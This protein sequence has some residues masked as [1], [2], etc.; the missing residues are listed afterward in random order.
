MVNVLWEDR[1]SV[2]VPQLDEEHMTILSL[3]NQIA[4]NQ[5]L[6]DWPAN[7]AVIL[8]QLT[9][10]AIG[11]CAREEAMLKAIGYP[12]L[13]DQQREHLAFRQRLAVFTMDMDDP[14]QQRRILNMLLSFLKE[15]WLEHI[16]VS[17]MKY[18]S[19]FSGAPERP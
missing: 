2:G 3:I 17:D 12:D 13:P 16:L 10:Y 5:D 1:Y 18:R 4:Q 7:L 9:N 19:Y 8:N 15:W 14:V 11:H 6:P